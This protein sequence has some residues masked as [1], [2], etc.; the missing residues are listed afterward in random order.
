MAS[1]T[2]SISTTKGTLLCALALALSLSACATDPRTTGSVKRGGEASIAQMSMSQLGA[3][4]RKWGARYER[5]PK[6]KQTGLTYASLL[7][8]TGR[9]DQALAVMRKMVIHHPK[10]N[11]VLSAYGKALAATGKLPEALDAIQR[12]Q[13]PD[14]PDWR[15]LSAEGA[16]LDQMER[17]EQARSLY[18]RALDIAPNEPTVLSNL[19]MSYLLTNDL[20]AAETYLHQAVRQSGADSRVRQNLAL[21]IGLQGRF[22]EA[23]RIASAELPPQEAAAN[24]EYLRGMLSQQNAWNLLKQEDKKTN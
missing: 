3:E 13:R 8:M 6:D 23:E 1:L 10:D 5:K 14:H 22:E 9:D 17:P 15:L 19:G 11:D 16:I 7:R 12:A 4:V 18:R 2:K 21:V 24:I 20:Q